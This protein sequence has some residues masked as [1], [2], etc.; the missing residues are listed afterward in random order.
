M[1]PLDAAF[2]S[3][4]KECVRKVGVGSINGLNIR[5]NCLIKDLIA[6][7]RFG[8]NV[9]SLRSAIAGSKG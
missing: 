2:G 3:G 8:E 5:R 9:E 7:F 6:L 1:H 4:L